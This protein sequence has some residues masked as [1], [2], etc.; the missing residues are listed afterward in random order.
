MKDKQ[1]YEKKSNEYSK[2]YPLT[3]MRNIIDANGDKNL[4]EIFKLY[5]HIYV[6]YID[7][8]EVTRLEIPSYLRRHGLWISYNK[9]GELY[10]EAY[11][12]DSATAENDNEWSNTDNWEYIPNLEYINNASLRIPEGAIL[13]EHLS[14]SILEMIA[15]AGAIINNFVDDED[16]TEK[17]CHVIKFKDKDYNPIIASGQGY[18]ILRKKFVN[19]IN[20]LN[21]EDINE[22]ETI[23]E[24]RYDFNLN[25]KTINLS[26]NASLW[27]KGGSI[28]NGN[29]IFNGG[30]IFGKVSF[31]DCGTANFSGKFA[32]GLVMY[33]S[34]DIKY[35]NGTEW[36]SFGTGGGGSTSIVD[37]EVE[38][39]ETTE[40]IA[41]ASARVENEV[42]KFSFGIPKGEKGEKGE[43]GDKGDTGTTGPQGPQGEPGPQG[44]AGDVAVA[45]QT[46]IV[47]KSTGQ[48]I[49]TP[50]TPIGGHWNSATDEFTPPNGWSRND[51]LD[52]IV[53]MS[54]G[55]FKADTGNIV[56][57]W[58]TPVRITGQD[59]ANGVDG[60]NI[61][62]IYKLTTTDLEKPSLTLTD[63]PNT[64]G[65][66]P[67]GWT[68]H[69]TGINVEYQCEWVS[70]RKKE[71]N[72]SWS[73]WTEPAIWSKWGVNGTDGD[74]VEYI[75]Y[76][77]N[78]ASVDNPTPLNTNT[79]EY[80]ER[81]DYE[82]I[83]YVP[84]GWEDN[85]QGVSIE[86][87][88]E[89]VSQ[90]KQKNGT[91]GA[92]SDPA[93]WAKYGNDGND[94]HSGLSL[95]TMYA[96]EEIGTTPVVV[97]DNINPGS[98]WGF[99]FPDYDSET[100][101]VWCIQAY[102]TYDN[103]LATTED[104]AA[105]EG[106]QGPWIVTGVPGESG[107]PPNYKTYIYKK[108]D[109]KPEKPTGTDKIPEGWEDYP[110]DTGQW[111]QC[112]G[113]VNGVTELVTEWSEVLPV[114][115]RDG[116]AQDGKYTEFRFSVSSSRESH[117]VLMR[118]MRNPVGWTITP[119]EI[120]K[121]NPVL[122]MTTAVINPNDTLYSNWTDPVVINGEQGPQGETGPAGEQGPAGSQGVSGIPGVSF[123]VR[124]CLGTENSYTGESTP[125]G[126]IPSGWF[127]EI[128][129]T[130]KQYPYIWCI[131]GKQIF[132]NS[133]GTIFTVSWSDPFRL[134]GTNGL[135]GSDGRKGQIIYPAGI[136][137]N[138]TS[139]TTDENKAP[140]VYDP[141]DGNF[142][143]LN[144][145]MTWLGTQ[146]NNRTPSQDYEQNDG[147]Y[148][149]KFEAF[150]AVYTKVGIIANGLIG[151]AVFNGDY[152]FSQQGIN[153][154]NNNI[155]TTDYQNF[156]S[157]H[158]YDGTFTP[159]FLVNFATGAGHYAAGIIK[160]NQRNSQF[161]V[162]IG[163][164]EEFLI[165]QD[166][167]VRYDGYYRHSVNYA[168]GATYSVRLPRIPNGCSKEIKF[169]IENPVRTATYLAIQNPTG[170]SSIDRIIY[171]KGDGK[172]YSKLGLTMTYSVVNNG[173][174]VITF[175]GVGE[176]I[177]EGSVYRNR[178]TWFITEDVIGNDYGGEA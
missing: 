165:E 44:P 172:Y 83:E 69:P 63:S 5:N 96:K 66:V 12:G 20:V 166:G 155:A 117:N 26:N 15:N 85:P 9:D 107:T 178:N 27:F 120:T 102:V 104:G 59:G 91:W 113:T 42:I 39:I 152:M 21:Q 139:Y 81:G 33:T 94:G 88:Y 131:Q 40:S 47:F 111:W 35:Y 19:G 79:D 99:I 36:I 64:N 16:L 6:D 93:V 45:T 162:I 127:E 1:L 22:E 174:A 89:W 30:C 122:W 118:N 57:E 154:S 151:S 52:G 18:K 41:T 109:T 125:V 177:K 110:N 105:Y 28:N 148:W 128:P 84:E 114:N 75:Y 157:S 74:G 4:L 70:T 121:E 147:K 167:T 101:A 80:Q 7:N 150:E 11:I 43:K 145:I 60:S 135:P 29:I 53:W 161:P 156:N 61:E 49:A 24:V 55:I 141:S 173:A 169:L 106:W 123:V 10:T 163:S 67:S 50:A 168:G 77:N 32:T 56:G 71:D 144:A 136:Y 164:N 2:I 130:T 62:F 31:I 124:Y 51:E 54:S 73:N 115:G 17:K 86:Y 23:Y 78:G 119:P 103:Q 48:S 146:Q 14:D 159:N 8:Q 92:F 142:Y 160:F 176:N 97:T 13:P 98:I 95:R 90:R 25:G 76:R 153:P 72:G 170:T 3:Y 65:Y 171:K 143:V 37:A 34:E 140:Y 133:S 132:A 46:F 158:I 129:T 126:L 68:N 82:D 108:S 149:L 175:H 100:E 112:I 58:T 116:T 38:S 138:T 134:T 137:S 87:K